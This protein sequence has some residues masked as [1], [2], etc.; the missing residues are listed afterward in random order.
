MVGRCALG[1]RE[2]GLTNRA[3]VISRCDCHLQLLNLLAKVM[4][5]GDKRGNATAVPTGWF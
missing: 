4:E 5:F 3:R 2:T 1:L